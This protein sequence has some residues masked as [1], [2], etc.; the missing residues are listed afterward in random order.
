MKQVLCLSSGGFFA[1]RVGVKERQ[2]TVKPFP[3]AHGKFSKRG[4]LEFKKSPNDKNKLNSTHTMSF[5]G[6]P[7]GRGTGAN[8]R[9]GGGFGSRGG[10]GGG[11]GGE[12]KKERKDFF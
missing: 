6:A 9:G 2:G 10:G 11:Y 4:N 3:R 8:S 12:S 5:R 7:R 1:Y